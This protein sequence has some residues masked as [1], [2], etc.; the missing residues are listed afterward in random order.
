MTNRLSAIDIPINN[1]HILKKP[2]ILLNN[3]L[4]MINDVTYVPRRH[5]SMISFLLIKKNDII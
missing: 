5:K 1:S 2:S 4:C 3:I